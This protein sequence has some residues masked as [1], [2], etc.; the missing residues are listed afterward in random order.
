MDNFLVKILNSENERAK[1]NIQLYSNIWTKF[2]EIIKIFW[3]IPWQTT[4]KIEPDNLFI[5]FMIDFRNMIVESTL[6]LVKDHAIQSGM[7]LRRALESMVFAIYVMEYDVQ[8]EILTTMGKHID[9]N[10]YFKII[11]KY[12]KDKHKNIAFDYFQKFNFLQD[13]SK[14]GNIIK[15]I[16]DLLSS[17]SSHSN[18]SNVFRTSLRKNGLNIVDDYFEQ[19]DDL[20]IIEGLKFIARI[21]DVFV[22][23][24]YLNNK[25]TKTVTTKERSLDYYKDRIHNLTNQLLEQ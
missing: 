8:T 16:K 15:K 13:N 12:F 19:R 9:D 11:S 1:E 20:T 24:V 18:V 23:L 5:L 7:L 2:N 10:D 17:D 4:K 6:A 22:Q 3:T 14:I 21:I 25:T